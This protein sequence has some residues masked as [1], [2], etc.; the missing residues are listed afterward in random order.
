[1][2]RTPTDIP[3]RA[4]VAKS[5]AAGRES[6]HILHC[7]RCCCLPVSAQPGCP[8][9][10]RP[11]L[12]PLGVIHATCRIALTGALFAKVPSRMSG[13]V[14]G[15]PFGTLYGFIGGFQA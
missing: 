15:G 5:E 2:R 12:S 14:S 6:G 13:I 9:A 10:H 7:V 11:V 4:R 1:M 3:N 8:T